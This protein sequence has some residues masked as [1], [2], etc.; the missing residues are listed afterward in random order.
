MSYGLRRIL[1]RN[2][3]HTT[4]QRRHLSNSTRFLLCL[5]RLR[6]FLLRSRRVPSSLLTRRVTFLR[7]NKKLKTTSP[8]PYTWVRKMSHY[9]VELGHST[10]C[11]YPRDPSLRSQTQHRSVGIQWSMGSIFLNHNTLEGRNQ[12]WGW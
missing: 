6:K 4:L 9:I 2:R 3:M 12:Y 5:C 11:G 10:I 1:R 7:L 8:K